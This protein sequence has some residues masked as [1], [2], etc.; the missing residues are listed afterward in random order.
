MLAERDFLF[1]AQMP[2]FTFGMVT[3]FLRDVSI[4]VCVDGAV[5]RA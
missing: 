4:Y 5:R 3:F 1:I 2:S